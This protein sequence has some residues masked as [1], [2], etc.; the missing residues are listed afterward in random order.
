MTL[1]PSFVTLSHVLNVITL[2]HCF[3]LACGFPLWVSMMCSQCTTS[4]EMNWHT[5]DNP[6][7]VPSFM[8]DGVV[9]QP[10]SL[11]TDL[12]SMP[13]ETRS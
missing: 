10:Y 1:V 12:Y 5:I 6:Q 7:R 11:G 13:V 8:H 3:D 4:F 2:F 9:H